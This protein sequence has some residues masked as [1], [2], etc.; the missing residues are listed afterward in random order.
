VRRVAVVGCGGSGKSVLARQLGV[1]LGIPVIHLDEIFY[2]HDWNPLT[3]NE[4]DAVQ[5]QL[6]TTPEWVIDGNYLSSMPIRLAASDTVVMMD[7]PT[8]MAL[9]GVFQRWW[10]YRSGQHGDGLHVRVT[11]E[12]LGYVASF[13][14]RVRPRVFA[15]VHEHAPAARLVVLGS[16]RA[17]RRFV[18]DL[19]QRQHGR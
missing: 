18:R 8:L 14:K 11:P 5:R 1:V 13:R 7:V 9:W 15:A 16:R 6:V 4:F 19:D 2:D 17:A 12:F 3:A 10:R